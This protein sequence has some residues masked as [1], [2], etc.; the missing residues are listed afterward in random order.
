MKRDEQGRWE[1]LAREDAKFYIK[2]DLADGED[3]FASGERDADGILALCDPFLTARSAALEIGCGVGRLTL[4]VSRRFGR[5]VAVDIAPTMLQHLSE[6]CAVRGATNVAPMLAGDRWE[7]H[8]PID[9]AY[10]RIVLQHIAAWSAI[11]DYLRRIAVSLAADGICYAQFDTRR[12][13]PLYH[14]KNALPDIVLPRTWRRGVRRIRRSMESIRAA[15][16]EAGLALALERGAGTH[17]TE[18]V[19]RKAG[20]S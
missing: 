18:L 10:S 12:H 4:P 16:T 11:E 3:F 1:A 6:N 13:T 15:A 14:L 19:F 2:T 8:G 9:F 20:A 5:V 17:D 7:L